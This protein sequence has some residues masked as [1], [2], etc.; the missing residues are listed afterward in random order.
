[1]SF[2]PEPPP[3]A[4]RTTPWEDAELVALDFEATGLH[5]GRD[6]VISF[7]TVPIVGGAIELGGCVYEL[8]DPGDRP[9]SAET[10][11]VHGLRPVDLRAGRAAP[12]ARED[13]RRQLRRREIVAWYA[14]VEIGFLRAMFGGRPAQWERRVLDVRNL[15]WALLGDEGRS[16]TLTQAAE[17]FGVPVASPHHALDDA[18]VTAQ[19]FLVTAAKLSAHDVL[20]VGDLR[21]LGPRPDPGLR[22]PRGPV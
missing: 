14:A 10:V 5:F 20:T 18:L 6:R 11:V 4:I 16:L 7:G 9:P 19:L 15:V 8:V 13:L 21:A 22:R 17:R 12:A 2:F 1:M 3:R